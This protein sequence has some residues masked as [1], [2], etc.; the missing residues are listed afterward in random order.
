MISI[1]IP[2]GSYRLLRAGMY[3]YTNIHRI[4]PHRLNPLVVWVGFFHLV[5]PVCCALGCLSF[6]VLGTLLVALS[7]ISVGTHILS[8]CT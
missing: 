3:S 1:M 5:H 4:S 8:S 7:S 6:V 2:T